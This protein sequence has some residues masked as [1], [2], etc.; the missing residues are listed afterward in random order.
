MRQAEDS[1]AASSAGDVLSSITSRLRSRRGEAQVHPEEPYFPLGL[2]I[3]HL[4]PMEFNFDLFLY[5]TLKLP[6]GLFQDDSNA[7]KTFETVEECQEYCQRFIQEAE[8]RR[9]RIQAPEGD[10]SHEARRS[11][12]KTAMFNNIGTSLTDIMTT[13]NV[14]FDAHLADLKL[15]MFGNVMFI[16]APSW[17][18][19][20][21]Q[22]THGY[23][24]R[25]ITASHAGILPGNLT[26]AAK[27]SNQ[28]I[29]SLSTGKK[30]EMCS[31]IKLIKSFQMV[32]QWQLKKFV[33][34][35]LLNSTFSKTVRGTKYH[36]ILGNFNHDHLK[37][38]NHQQT[39]DF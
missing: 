30:T 29:R 3:S 19:L 15:D 16:R 10:R 21:V 9:T 1:I 6:H 25:L 35:S 38:E 23:P 36:A 13:G 28:A 26:V 39:E 2:A 24:R 17:S 11:L 33:F 31:L 22:F 37:F 18:D 34:D 32:C 12:S 27:I 14:A 8:R 7:A 4:S 5:D 20:A